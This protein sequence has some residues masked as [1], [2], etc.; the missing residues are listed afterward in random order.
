MIHGDQRT[1]EMEK[2]GMNLKSRRFTGVMEHWG[3][4]KH[5]RG[6]QVRGGHYSL[7]LRDHTAGSVAVDS[8]CALNKAEKQRAFRRL[9]RPAWQANMRTLGI[10]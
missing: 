9:L 2:K 8:Q 10:W 5:P 1:L 7:Q 3:L 4:C 6:F